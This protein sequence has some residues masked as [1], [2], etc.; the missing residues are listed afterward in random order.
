M[1]GCLESFREI[2]EPLKNGLVGRAVRF[3]LFDRPAFGLSAR[4]LPDPKAAPK[5]SNTC[6]DNPYTT[7]FVLKIT[8]SLYSHLNIERVI[9]LG[10]QQLKHTKQK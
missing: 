1:G 4:E 2:I 9:L 10:L 3:V 5:Y 7:E 6:E 8:E